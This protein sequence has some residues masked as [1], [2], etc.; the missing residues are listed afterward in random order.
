MGVKVLQCF[1]WYKRCKDKGKGRDCLPKEVPSIEAEPQ[2][3]P[4]TY[5]SDGAGGGVVYFSHKARVAYRHRME[6]NVIDTTY[7]APN[8][9]PLLQKHPSKT[10]CSEASLS[11]NRQ[12][13]SS[14]MIVSGQKNTKMMVKNKMVRKLFLFVFEELSSAEGLR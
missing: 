13:P 6:G 1:P 8:L 5:A 3:V 12:Y 11:Y 10:V 9:Q 4:S 14:S 7:W 2:F